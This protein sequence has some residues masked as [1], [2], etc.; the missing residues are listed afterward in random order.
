[1]V[2]HLSPKSLKSASHPIRS[3]EPGVTGAPPGDPG[4]RLSPGRRG[5]HCMAGT[6][7]PADL[8]PPS[9]FGAE[10]LALAAKTLDPQFHHI[11]VLQ[12][13]RWLHPHA[14]TGRG[15]G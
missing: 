4:P 1:M 2:N 11:A 12:K 9:L 7:R 3:P 5:L 13:L 8:I 14:D 10:C 6:P 15:A